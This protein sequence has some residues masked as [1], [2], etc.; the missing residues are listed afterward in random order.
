MAKQKKNEI[1]DAGE[2][3]E[4]FFLNT[5][6]A[7]GKK[8]ESE[9]E[10]E[11]EKKKP[12]KEEKE[13]EIALGDFEEEPEP[14]KKK[15]KEEKETPEEPEPEPESKPE[16]DKDRPPE[17][18]LENDDD[19]PLLKKQEEPEKEKEEE[20][21]ELQKEKKDK[22]GEEEE[23][24]APEEEIKK[25]EL[26]LDEEEPESEEEEPK[27]IDFVGLGEELGI[28]IKDNNKES[29]VKAYNEKIEEAKQKVEPDLS[30]FTSDQKI[31]FDWLKEEDA[32][33]EDF[34][35][36]LKAFDDFKILPEDERIIKYLISEEELDENKAKERLEEI[37]EDDKFDEYVGKV[38]DLVDDLREEEFNKIITSI[39]TAQQ[40]KERERQSA[41]RGE[42]DAMLKV[43]DETN[44]FL[45]LPLAQ[46]LKT[47]MK[48]KVE[49]GQLTIENNNAETQ[50]LGHYFMLFGDKVIGKM[51]AE[52]KNAVDAAYNRGL[53]KIKDKLHNAPPESEKDR[54]RRGH[55]LP[56]ED[57]APLSGLKNIDSEAKDG[58]E[59]N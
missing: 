24:E 22:K 20:E 7:K 11:P 35:N 48:A 23:E 54:G 4:E 28:E 50:I 36:P 9:E 5:E 25:D 40:D 13:E 3:E 2:L 56:E 8:A 32:T 17:D 49:K 58:F 41:E 51:E 46:N 12:E 52:K 29:F 59:G 19:I 45:G 21:D 30:N 34:F 47:K 18:Q 14:E 42:K 15:K 57:T 55:G 16:K 26:D 44:T 6:E 10:P 33:L 27:G 39:K 53:K 38:N 37:V 43:I 1:V 31:L